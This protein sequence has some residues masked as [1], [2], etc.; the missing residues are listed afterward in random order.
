MDLLNVAATSAGA[1]IILFLLTKLIGNKQMSQM[2][3]FDY[4]NGITIGSIAA[5]M[6]TSLESDFLQP[7]LAMVIFA[8]LTILMDLASNH[9]FRARRFFE[10]KSIILM[11]NGKLYYKQFRR[12]RVDINEF[13]GQCRNNGYFRL[14]DLHTVI[15]EPNGQMSFLPMA[16]AHPATPADL[17]LPPPQ[18]DTAP[19][20]LIA[21]GQLLAH[22]LHACGKDSNWLQKQ[23]AAQNIKQEEVFLATNDGS[24]TLDVWK[25]EGSKT[26]RDRFQ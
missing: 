6:A 18:Q 26:K 11:E 22:N 20:T 1:L 5:E 19:Y 7:A 24:N 8:L 4:I 3:L 17:K 9:S 14:T 13:L 12:A 2:N 16:T 15:L 21:D 23:L 25:R 10:G